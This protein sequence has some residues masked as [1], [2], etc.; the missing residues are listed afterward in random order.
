M[1]TFGIPFPQD[2]SCAPMD[3]ILVEC[4]VVQT[5]EIE[6]LILEN[7]QTSPIRVSNIL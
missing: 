6:H 7:K 1:K 5:S 4:T 2:N 3:R